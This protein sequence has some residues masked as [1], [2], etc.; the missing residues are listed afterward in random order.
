MNDKTIESKHV[1]IVLGKCRGYRVLLWRL[2][3]LDFQVQNV[4]LE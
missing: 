3:M 4:S 1:G 2:F